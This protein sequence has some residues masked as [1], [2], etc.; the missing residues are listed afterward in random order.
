MLLP[1]SG[2]KRKVR[3][4]AD[5]TGIRSTN[6]QKDHA[7]LP[8]DKSK[9]KNQILKRFIQDSYRLPSDQKEERDRRHTNSHNI[10]RL[11]SKGSA[12]NRGKHGSRNQGLKP[13]NNSSAEPLKVEFVNM[14]Q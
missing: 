12:Q 14:S 8:K 2:E 10:E 6:D 7:A 13:K 9:F 4:N 1:D 3:N 11:S 5:G